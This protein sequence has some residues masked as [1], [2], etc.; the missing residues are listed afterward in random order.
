MG[1]DGGSRID[2]NSKNSYGQTALSWVAQNGHEEVSGMLLE[3][4]KVK[5]GDSR[6]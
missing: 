4:D 6:D 5:D 2:G 1:K 3:L